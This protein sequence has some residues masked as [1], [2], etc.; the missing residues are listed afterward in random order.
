MEKDTATALLTGIISATDRF[1]NEKTTAD[2]MAL[3]AKLM[4]AGQISS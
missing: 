4:E 1:L 3:A 2:T